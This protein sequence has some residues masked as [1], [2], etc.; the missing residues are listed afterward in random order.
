MLKLTILFIALCSYAVHG[1][2][3]NARYDDSKIGQ[4]VAAKECQGTS[5]STDTCEYQVCCSNTTSGGLSS[6]CLDQNAFTSVYNTSRGKYIFKFLDHGINRTGICTN[7]R[8]KAAFLAIAAAMTNDFERDEVPGRS[9]AFAYDDQ[10][11]GN[12][13][14][15]D[16]SLFRRRGFFGLRGK[17]IY[18]RLQASNRAFNVYSKPELA[19]DPKTAAEI[20]AILWNR[21]DLQS[22]NSF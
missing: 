1:Q 22:G 5:L 8:A 16:G 4:C 18:E 12:S 20:A 2:T 6:G 11:Y 3:C 7:C 13:D 21:P 10:R 17:D 15:D 19:A 9:F 14:R